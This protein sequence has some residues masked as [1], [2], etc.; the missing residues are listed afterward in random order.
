LVQ[1][2]ER[3]WADEPDRCISKIG[4]LSISNGNITAI[5]TSLGSG[6]GTTSIDEDE[7]E[8]ITHMSP[9]NS[10]IE[11]LSIASGR[12][13]A[14]GVGAG[15]GGKPN[16]F[17]EVTRLRFNGRAMMFCNSNST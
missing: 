9:S 16:G 14:I 6:I 1:A 3:Q 8:Q 17:D 10:V 15:I 11:T 5:S 2:L 12:I 13:T 4:N 7:S